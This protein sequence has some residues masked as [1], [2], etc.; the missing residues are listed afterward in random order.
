ML[1]ID[2]NRDGQIAASELVHV[3]TD[4]QDSHFT[5]RNNL[6]WLDSNGDG[7]LDARDPAFAALRVWVDV[8]SDG[9][10]GN[11]P[12]GIRPAGNPQAGNMTGNVGSNRLSQYWLTAIASNTTFLL[13]A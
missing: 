11:L 3:N 9:R 5:A 6:A 12:A 2:R 4:R 8:N 7:K 13:S 1:V 10:T